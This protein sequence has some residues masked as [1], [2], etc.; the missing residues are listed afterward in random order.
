MLG[1]VIVSE[2]ALTNVISKLRKILHKNCPDILTI[3]T[4]SKSG[5][6]LEVV[7]SVQKESNIN[8]CDVTAP[9]VKEQTINSGT[10]IPFESNRAKA[11]WL[12][13]HKI[14]VLLIF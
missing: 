7:G 14:T 6:L 12:S 2:Q 5:Y 9:I 1:D 3:T 11:S 4:V 13:S 10:A 8:D